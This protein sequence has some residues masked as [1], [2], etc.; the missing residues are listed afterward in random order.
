MLERSDRLIPY[1]LYKSES[2]KTDKV[3]PRPLLIMQ[4]PSP[5]R[6][7]EKHILNSSVYGKMEDMQQ[8]ADTMH[9]YYATW[10]GRLQH[11]RASIHLALICCCCCCCCCFLLLPLPPLL[12]PCLLSATRSCSYS[13]FANYFFP[14]IATGQVASSGMAM[15]IFAFRS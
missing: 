13:F 12:R 11:G 3:L 2:G 8:A 5:K 15:Q 4:R 1:M 14:N 6:A 9:M 7:H 10:I